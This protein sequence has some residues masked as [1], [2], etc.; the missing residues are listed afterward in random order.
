MT[1]KKNACVRC[2]GVMEAGFIPDF[3]SAGTVPMVWHPGEPEKSFWNGIV[4]KKKEVLP[5]RSHRCSR[6]GY[7]EFFARPG[8]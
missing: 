3:S 2:H 6:C 4:V 1:L 8:Q 5:I 7:L